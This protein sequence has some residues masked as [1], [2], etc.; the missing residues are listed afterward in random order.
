MKCFFR[1]CGSFGEIR[2]DLAREWQKV[3]QETESYRISCEYEQDAYGVFTRNDVFENVSNESL[4]VQCLKSRFVFDGGEYQVYTQFNAW[5]NE[6]FGGWQPLVSSV[7][8]TGGS[9]RLTK[10]AAPFMVL[11]DEQENRGVAFHLVPNCSWEMKVTRA[12]H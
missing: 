10:D 4:D 6:S 5:Q 11:W 12:S 3:F 7:G 9:S 8:V 2:G 1:G